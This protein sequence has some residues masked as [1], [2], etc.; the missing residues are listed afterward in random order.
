[1][2]RNDDD[3]EVEDDRAQDESCPSR[4]LMSTLDLADDIKRNT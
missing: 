3:H 1:M 2:S 4:K